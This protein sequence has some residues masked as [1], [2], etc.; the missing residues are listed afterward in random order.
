MINLKIKKSTNKNKKYD[1]IFTDDDGNYKK[2]S[3]GAVR[4]NGIPYED[5]TTHGDEKRKQL[6]LARHRKNEDWNNFLTAGSLS[7][8]LLWNKPTLKES[9]K[10]FKYL[11]QLN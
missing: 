8:Y 4:P 11:F 5:F 6:Y 9:I 10:N 7:R 3:F 2:V 1:A